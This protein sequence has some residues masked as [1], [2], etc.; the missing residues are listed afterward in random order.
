M[1]DFTS[2]INEIYDSLTSIQKQVADY[3]LQ[4]LDAVAFKKLEE[5]SLEIGVSTTSVIRFARSLGYNGY[6][7]MQQDLQQ[8]LIGKASLPERL[9]DSIKN[10][11]QDKLLID[12]FQNDID[13]IHAT[14]MGLSEEDLSKAVSAIINAKSVYVVGN[15]G[16]FSVAHYIAYRLSQ[17]KTGVRLIQGIG[18]MFP[19]EISNASPED[20]CIAILTPR[21]SKMTASIVSWFKKHGITVILFTKQGNTEID[22]Y[23]DIIL[24]CCTNSISYKSSFVSLFCVCNYLLAAVALEDHDHT[25]KVI[26]QTEE[27]LNN[28]YYLGL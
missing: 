4:H 26:A 7:D 15:R 27:I 13:N 20:V 25:M 11:K 2:N 9:S 21:Y 22:P 10:T 5:L 23:G 6:A 3:L 28:G 8:G 19:E 12:T 1:N 18:M 14:L 16:A 24:P 17:I